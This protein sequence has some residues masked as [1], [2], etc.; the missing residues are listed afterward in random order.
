MR[1]E[2]AVAI[3]TAGALAAAGCGRGKTLDAAAIRKEAEAVRSL[4]AEGGLLAADAAK[5]RT[6]RPFA[7]THAGELRRTAGEE[8]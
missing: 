3:A 6:Y 1:R 8:A 2:L 7:R 4:A 5:G